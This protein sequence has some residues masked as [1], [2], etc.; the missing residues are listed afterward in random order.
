M[1]LNKA[2]IKTLDPIK[3][4]FK[5]MVYPSLENLLMALL[6]EDVHRKNYTEMTPMCAHNAIKHNIHPMRKIAPGEY[7]QL[8]IA[9][10]KRVRGPVD[11][12]DVLKRWSIHAPD[13]TS[14]KET[15][16]EY[17]VR[18]NRYHEKV[19]NKE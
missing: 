10:L 14:F 18:R 4:T 9:V 16:T 2:M 17:I 12:N 11:M 1:K 6:T 15:L 13:V 19:D 8:C 7:S 3:V 5:G